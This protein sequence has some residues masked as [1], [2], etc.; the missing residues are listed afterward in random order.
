MEFSA[1]QDVLLPAHGINQ[2]GDLCFCDELPL[3]FGEWDHHFLRRHRTQPP[4]LRATLAV[5]LGASP[6]LR[7]VAIRW[8]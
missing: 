4:S 8:V 7:A 5:V 3:F 2:A 6:Q 1:D